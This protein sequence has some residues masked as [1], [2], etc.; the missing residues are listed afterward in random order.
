MSV[1]GAQKEPKG[2][3]RESKGVQK[4]P[5]GCLKGAQRCPRMRKGCSM[6][7][8]WSPRYAQRP[9]DVKIG[10]QIAII[11]HTRY[12]QMTKNITSLAYLALSFVPLSF[13]F[14]V[15][16]MLSVC[17]SICLSVCLSVCL[18]LSL[19]LRFCSYLCLPLLV[20]LYVS[21]SVFVF[22]SLWARGENLRWFPPYLRCVADGLSP[23]RQF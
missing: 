6:G 1:K 2:W 3:P 12:Q 14:S 18:S 4:V 22:A 15:S 10:A 8:Q 7:G 23:G 17:L 5:K 11:H 19:P 9:R 21:F 16:L 13:Y 20:Y